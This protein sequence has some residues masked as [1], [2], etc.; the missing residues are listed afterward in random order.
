[1]YTCGLQESKCPTFVA[2][3]NVL[4][5]FVNARLYKFL[6]KFDSSPLFHGYVPKLLSVTEINTIL[7]NSLMDP[8]TIN[9]NRRTS[10]CLTGSKIPEVNILRGMPEF[11]GIK[12]HQFSFKQS[13]PT[14]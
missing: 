8:T 11:Q 3:P 12:D 4:Y 10:A 9:N 13:F 6:A 1:M 2:I 7:S 14:V 5:N